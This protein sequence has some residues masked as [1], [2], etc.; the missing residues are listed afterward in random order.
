MAC[1]TFLV[2]PSCCKSSPIVHDGSV[3]EEKQAGRARRRVQKV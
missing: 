3:T 2:E 1:L